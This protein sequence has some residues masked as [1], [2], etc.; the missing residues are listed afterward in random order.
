MKCHNCDGE[1]VFRNTLCWHCQKQ[2]GDAPK[3]D[4]EVCRG[5]GGGDYACEYCA[6]TG[7]TADQ[8][9]F[10]FTYWNVE[11]LRLDLGNPPLPRKGP[12]DSWRIPLD[13]T[14]A[15]ICEK[16]G[17]SEKTH[18]MYFEQQ[19]LE[20]GWMFQFVSV[21]D[22]EI[23]W[24]WWQDLRRRWWRYW[25]WKWRWRQDWVKPRPSEAQL[26]AA[27]GRALGR[28]FAWYFREKGPE[29]IAHV[30]FQERPPTEELL[31]YLYR[32]LFER[33]YSY[34]IRVWEGNIATGE[35]GWDIFLT[36]ADGET[37][38]AELGIGYTLSV[39]VA[40][41]LNASFSVMDR[42]DGKRKGQ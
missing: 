16:L 41:A 28:H 21:Y 7:E 9:S 23:E 34:E 17:V 20:F 1:G 35:R 39:A 4:C 25:A 6:G 40:E 26:K 3:P 32:R 38:Y 5:Q 37:V 31:D 19:L 29:R 14:F 10:L 42:V 22:N 2:Y 11:E 18:F 8:Y 13:E 36:S 27:A 15:E 30:A 33:G 24:T 12:H